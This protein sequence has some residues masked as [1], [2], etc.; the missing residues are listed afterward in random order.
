MTEPTCRQL[1]DEIVNVIAKGG[2]SV[3]G[4]GVYDQLLFDDLRNG[5]LA[6]AMKVLARKDGKEG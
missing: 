2:R 6:D 3:Q 5:W 4:N 1:L